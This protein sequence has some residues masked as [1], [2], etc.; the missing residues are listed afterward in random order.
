[1]ENNQIITLAAMTAAA[2]GVAAYIT[3]NSETSP[4]EVEMKQCPG[5]RFHLGIETGGTTCKIGIMKDVKAL[6]I[7]RTVTIVTTAP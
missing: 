2:V 7:E 1:M 6:K 5:E 3:G 4:G